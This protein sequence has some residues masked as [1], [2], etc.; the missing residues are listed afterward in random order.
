MKFDNWNSIILTHFPHT[1]AWLKMHFFRFEYLENIIFPI[2][3][4]DKILHWNL[5]AFSTKSS[6][7]PLTNQ[8]LTWRF[9]VDLYIAFAFRNCLIFVTRI[10]IP[11]FDIIWDQSFVNVSVFI[12]PMSP[13]K[14]SL[15]HSISADFSDSPCVVSNNVFLAE[16]KGVLSEPPFHDAVV[17][18]I[19]CVEIESMGRLN[20]HSNEHPIVCSN[21]VQKQARVDR[22]NPRIPEYSNLLIVAL[23]RWFSSLNNEKVP[24]GTVFW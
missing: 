14:T 13:P 20:D 18:G 8:E 4:H 21:F 1:T 7:S 11:G 10:H 12:S 16:W 5:W 24:K 3:Q 15:N 19:R 6:N 22:R 17:K 23:T 9:S 2:L